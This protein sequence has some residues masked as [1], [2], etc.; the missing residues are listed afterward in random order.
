MGLPEVQLALPLARSTDPSSSA[1]AASRVWRGWP[2]RILDVLAG[3]C[4]CRVCICEKLGADPKCWPTISSA[5]S[6][7]KQAGLLEPV[8]YFCP[9]HDAEVYARVFVARVEVRGDVL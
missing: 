4:F 6:R 1:R 3:N 9:D 2:A 7:L 5:C 8:G